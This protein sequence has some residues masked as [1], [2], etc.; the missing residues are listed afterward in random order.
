[1]LRGEIGYL[2]KITEIII[3]WGYAG[4]ALR[5]WNCRRELQQGAAP[6]GFCGILRNEHTAVGWCR[7]LRPD[8]FQEG[9]LEHKI[10]LRQFR[11]RDSN[12]S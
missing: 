6:R 10:H 5:I 3:S 1:M 11:V 7:G 2:R 12:R 4:D 9:H 8:I